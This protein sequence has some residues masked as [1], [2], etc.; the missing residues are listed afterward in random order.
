MESSLV[1]KIDAALRANGLRIVEYKANLG[2]S[3][4]NYP[5]VTLK[6][7]VGLDAKDDTQTVDALDRIK[8]CELS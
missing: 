7:I 6:V 5:T 3:V 4:N 1:A 8:G 2:E